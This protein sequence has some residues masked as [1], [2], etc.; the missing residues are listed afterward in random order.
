MV[1]SIPYRTLE[2][3]QTC[4]DGLARRY[5]QNGVSVLTR[6]SRWPQQWDLVSDEVRMSV[7][8]AED[9]IRTRDPLVG[10][11]MLYH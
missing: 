3:P 8:G 1:V 5:I 7:G 6:R 11:E 10:N 4:C 2:T 9:G